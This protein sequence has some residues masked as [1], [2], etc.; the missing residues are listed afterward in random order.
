[1]DIWFY[2]LTTSLQSFSNETLSLLTFGLCV[3]AILLMM[4][5]FQAPGLLIYNA[6]MTIIANI[7]VLKVAQFGFSPEPVALGTIAFATIF[8]TS[9]IL[10][11]HYG[12]SV[13]RQGV[14]LCF[15]GQLL[16]IALMLITLGH[17]PT[18]GSTIH[19][20]MEVIFLPSP[21]LLVASLTAFALSQLLE[22]TVFNWMSQLTH[23][24]MLWLRTNVATLIAA[25]LDNIVFSSLAWVI[26]AP[27]PVNWQ[28]LIFTYI[29]GTYFARVLVSIFSTPV[30][31]LSYLCI[32][33]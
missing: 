24:K 11:E 28:T 26:L 25:L 4:R 16:T 29:L 31:Y 9:D 13:A 8:L 12:S 23:R 32:K 14:G 33:K 18:D 22:I 30:I 17:T 5:W 21:R 20:A 3:A 19:H 2:T 10:T 27:E 6:L 1:M 15:I 7:Q